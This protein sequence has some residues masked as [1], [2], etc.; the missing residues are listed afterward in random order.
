MHVSNHIGSR[1]RY[2]RI[3]EN[4]IE[5]IEPIIPWHLSIDESATSYLRDLRWSL[6]G[7]RD[8]KHWIA[9]VNVALTHDHDVELEALLHGLPPH[10]F[11]DGINAHVAEVAAMGLLPLTL[12][13]KVV[14]LGGLRH[15]AVAKTD[16][17]PWGMQ[18]GQKKKT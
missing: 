16:L 6:V 11:Q 9:I 14:G 18:V 1:F 4:K 7:G 10:L 2:L 12:R 15:V 5:P 8:S 17:W 3:Y 13:G